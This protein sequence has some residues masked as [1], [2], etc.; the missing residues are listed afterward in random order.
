M[1]ILGVFMVFWRLCFVGVVLYCVQHV[2]GVAVVA[3]VAGV[4]VVVSLM[5][6]EEANKGLGEMG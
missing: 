1:L 5:E 3:V 4:A 6:G 2:A